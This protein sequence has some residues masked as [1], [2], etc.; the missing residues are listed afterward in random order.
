VLPEMKANALDKAL[1]APSSLIISYEISAK[2]SM[3][4]SLTSFK[5]I[6]MSRALDLMISTG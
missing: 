1:T 6:T 2:Y 5:L 4:W 3:T